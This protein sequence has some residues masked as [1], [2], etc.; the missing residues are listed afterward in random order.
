MA[1]SRIA[2]ILSQVPF[3]SRRALGRRICDEFPFVDAAGHLLVAG[4]IEAPATLADSVLEIVL[5]PPRA[6]AAINRSHRL[7]ADVP[8]PVGVPPR[9][10]EIDGLSLGLV[11]TLLGRQVPDCEPQLMFTDNELDFLR[12]TALEHVMTA[13]DRFG[14]AV[15]LA[16]HLRGYP[17]RSRDP[18]PGNQIM[19]HGQAR[20]SGAA[21]GRRIE[22]R[23]GR[24]HALRQDK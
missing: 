5:P 8:L 22:F 18:E 21:L 23:N 1:V 17:S 11:I 16:A 19:W 7:E 9:Q 24:G 10:A 14:D 4:C 2:A 20:F 15:R 6:P 3:D 12:D 13:P